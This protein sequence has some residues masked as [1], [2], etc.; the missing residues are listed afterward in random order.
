MRCACISVFQFQPTGFTHRI[1][2]RP[3]WRSCLQ[4]T[5]S[6]IPRSSPTGSAGMRET[7]NLAAA[8]ANEPD[9]LRQA[10]EPILA[11]PVY[12]SV[13]DT[14]PGPLADACGAA[15]ADRPAAVTVLA[16]DAQ[17]RLADTASGTGKSAPTRRRLARCVS[18]STSLI[19]APGWADSSA[20]SAAR[21]FGDRMLG[22]V[23][24]TSSR[25][26]GRRAETARRLCPRLESR[27][28]ARSG[29]PSAPLARGMILCVI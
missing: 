26:G 28:S 20:I 22:I 10:V 16:T 21:Q 11:T 25:R 12:L 2:Q 15:A 29:G 14:P 23:Y 5:P 4:E 8:V 24:L 1:A 27:T 3:D 7:I 6:G 18:F 19:R 9:M 17:L 13:V